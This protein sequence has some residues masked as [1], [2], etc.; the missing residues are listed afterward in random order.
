MASLDKE[1]R[2]LASVG[3]ARMGRRI[4]K[5]FDVS[6]ASIFASGGRRSFP[7]LARRSVISLKNR[8]FEV[9]NLDRSEFEGAIGTRRIFFSLVSRRVCSV[10]NKAGAV[11]RFFRVTLTNSN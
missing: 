4:G 10:G 11:R 7:L 8:R 9:G 5:S 3:N 2:T 6:F 1:A